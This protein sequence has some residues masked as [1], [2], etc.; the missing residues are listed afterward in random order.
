MKNRW[1]G[2]VFTVL[3]FVF[4]FFA[5]RNIAAPLLDFH[6][7]Q[8]E[9]KLIYIILASITIGGLLLF[10]LVLYFPP[11]ASNELNPSSTK[12]PASPGSKLIDAQCA[13]SIGDV[14]RG[15]QLLNSVRENDGDYWFSRK[16][17]GDFLA[18]KGDW[19]EAATEYRKALKYASDPDRAFVFLALGQLYETQD[20]LE[21][22]RDLYQQGL[23]LAP[24]SREIV[25]RLRSLAVRN[26]DWPEAIIWQEKL[27][28]EFPEHSEDPQD[29]NWKIGIRYEL[30]REACR[31][32]SYKT[33]NAILKFIFRMTDYFAPAYLLQGEMHEMQQSAPAGFR[34]FEQGFRMTQNPA[35][36]KKIGETLLRQNQ[37]GKAIE[38]LRDIVRENPDDPRAAFCLADL[39]RKL[40]MH[41]EAIKVFENIRQ[42]NPDW[43]LNNCALADLYYRSKQ[44]ESALRIYR[45][46]VDGTEGISPSPWECYNCNTTYIEYSGFCMVCTMWNTINLNQNKAGMKDFGYEKSTALPL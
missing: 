31:N 24:N 27:E 33:A 21:E 20:A 18:E 10:L 12:K 14:E 2:V 15:I 16:I 5:A 19:N 25:V 23:R 40:E 28:V 8:L 38:S 4:L 37:P 39:Y 22:A 43:I 34:S 29:A 7:F 11:W 41:E 3:F 9:S 13:L 6:L 17:M 32:G 36:L 42:K 45:T 44:H 35:L 26:Q 30:A 46:V 1:I